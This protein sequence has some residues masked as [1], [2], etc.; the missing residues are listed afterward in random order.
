[1][2]ED[3]WQRTRHVGCR[4]L[5]F[6]SR[7][8]FSSGKEEKEG[9]GGV[10][11]TVIGRRV[12]RRDET[13]WVRANVGTCA[14]RCVETDTDARRRVDGPKP[15]RGQCP[16]EQ[17]GG[18]RRE[19]IGRIKR[20]VPS[21]KEAR[22]T[23]GRRRTDGRTRE[24]GAERL[25]EVMRGIGAG[26]GSSGGVG[27]GREETEGEE[28]QTFWRAGSAA[29]AIFH[30]ADVRFRRTVTAKYK[31]KWRTKTGGR[32]RGTIRRDT[33][34]ERKIGERRKSSADE[35]GNGGKR[36]GKRTIAA[37]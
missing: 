24:F 10:T 25:K 6:S 7:V 12:G 1:M 32:R 5:S 22:G 9:R 14:A 31:Q 34:R 35:E 36:G 33:G 17:K 2:L 26:R 15:D 30:G 13:A 11:I 28:G 4:F 19:R 3:S 37:A 20:S 29:A 21:T 16:K 27:R 8:A 23:T 18:T